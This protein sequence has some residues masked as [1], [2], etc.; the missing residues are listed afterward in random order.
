VIA[1]ASAGPSKPRDMGRREAI[2]TER[3]PPSR[4]GAP[5]S[6][7]TTPPWAPPVPRGRLVAP[8]GP[9]AFSTRTFKEPAALRRS[10][11]ECRKGGGAHPRRAS[12]RGG[13]RNPRRVR[14]H[15]LPR[16]ELAEIRRAFRQRVATA[17]ALKRATRA[18]DKR[19]PKRKRKPEPNAAPVPVRERSTTT[20]TYSPHDAWPMSSGYR[21][22][23]S[24]V[25]PKP[26]CCR[27]FAPSADI[28]GSGG[29]T[30]E[31][32][33]LTCPSPNPRRNSLISR[34]A[35]SSCLSSTRA[36]S[37]SARASLLA[38]WRSNGADSRRARPVIALAVVVVFLAGVPPRTP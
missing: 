38:A 11:P 16:R 34:S 20:A 18:V 12:A 21:R 9:T 33:A 6:H 3:L 5:P 2:W 8:S 28:A 14:G 26:G 23:L 24:G 22:I 35:S 7:A 37:R 13:G 32:G 27:R 15:L 19:E 1:L 4:V 17:S 36:S 25:G 30:F 31:R 10:F 29:V